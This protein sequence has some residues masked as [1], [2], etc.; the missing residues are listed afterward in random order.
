[1]GY[2]PKHVVVVW[3]GTYS[4][5]NL[6]SQLTSVLLSGLI[7]Y[8]SR[9]LPPDDWPVPEDVTALNVCDPSGLLPTDDCPNVVR[10]VFLVG[11]EPHQLDPLFRKF[12]INR[13]T[14]LLATI[15]TPPQL[16]EERLYMVV[17]PEARAWAESANIPLPPDSYDAIQPP[18]LD[19]D[20]RITLPTLFSE[21]S[22]LV[23]V[24][25]QAAGEDFA[26]YR[27]LAGKGLN[28][29]E[30]IEIT[31]SDQP[32]AD[33]LLGEWDTQGLTGLYALELL[34][35]RTDQ[36]VDTAVTQVTIASESQ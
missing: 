1:V 32:V 10:E 19:P 11:S 7:Q 15:F 34:V 5:Q 8:A 21:V 29:L 24:T 9:N 35:T 17:P 6:S 12:S 23:K 22:G 36:K 30:W 27:L 13:E 31:S 14:G 2:T 28:P 20:V 25:G 4:D 18:V 33:G 16:V 26:S 3:A